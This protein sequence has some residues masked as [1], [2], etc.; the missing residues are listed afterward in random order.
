MFNHTLSLRLRQ[1][2]PG[3]QA[4]VVQSIRFDTRVRLREVRIPTTNGLRLSIIMRCW[5]VPNA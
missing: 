4:I 3:T 5:D 1:Q 2:A